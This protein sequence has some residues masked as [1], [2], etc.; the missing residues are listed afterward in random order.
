MGGVD[1]VLFGQLAQRQL[2]MQQVVSLGSS[3]VDDHNLAAIVRLISRDCGSIFAGNDSAQEILVLH[4]KSREQGWK[5]A[6][7]TFR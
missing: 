7:V 1:A 3:P 5:N 4:A 6:P 2:R